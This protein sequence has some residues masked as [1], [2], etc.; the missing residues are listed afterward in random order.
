MKSFTAEFRGGL[1]HI[2]HEKLG[3]KS[4][5]HE[6]VE[7]T[8][9]SINEVYR[10]QSAAGFFIL[11]LNSAQQF[12][13]MFEL[14]AEGLEAIRKT[15]T[16]AVP[17]VIATGHFAYQSYLLLEYIETGTKTPA[18]MQLLG[19]QLAQMHQNTAEGFGFENDNY[20][21]SL[22]QSNKK[23]S[24]WQSFF[25]EERLKPMV[26]LAFD[27]SFIDQK[28]VSDFENLYQKLGGFF[29]EEKPALIHGDLWGSN[30]LIGSEGKPYLI[31][32]AVSYGFREFDLAMTHLFG[33]FSTDFYKAY[34]EKF[35]LQKGWQQRVDLWNLY[36]LL[37]HLNLFGT[38]YLGQVRSAVRKFI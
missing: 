6:I 11:K 21:G 20:M 33:G 28:L 15:K 3:G 22:P 27:A 34:Q 18:A 38:G 12:P 1:E 36:P 8:G 19:S 24:S 35:P 25:I 7:V 30:Y 32:P 16:V 37:L 5:I 9:G 2:L 23:H 10:L 26:K 14:E 17:E 13:K 31:D 4:S 29:E